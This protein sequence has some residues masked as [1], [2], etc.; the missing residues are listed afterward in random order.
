[1][2]IFFEQVHANQLEFGDFLGQLVELKNPPS[3]EILLDLR[4]NIAFLNRNLNE[5]LTL[6]A[7]ISYETQQEKK[8]HSKAEIKFAYYFLEIAL[9][10]LRLVENLKFSD[11]LD[12]KI[13]LLEDLLLNKWT[14]IETEFIEIAREELNAFYN[15]EIRAKL[16]SDLARRH[17]FLTKN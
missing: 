10:I 17:S 2:E 14:L 1:M 13:T 11:Y 7:E 4:K 12:E 3:E 16:E 6:Y 5:A 15:V 8:V 9:Q